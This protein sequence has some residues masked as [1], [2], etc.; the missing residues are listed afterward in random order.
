MF[1]MLKYLREFFLIIVSYIL[2]LVSENEE[3]CFNG[4]CCGGRSV[5]LIFAT[6]EK[7]KDSRKNYETLTCFKKMLSILLGKVSALNLIGGLRYVF[8]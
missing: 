6:V 7:I 5:F 3:D 1:I 2:Q 8:V 4:I